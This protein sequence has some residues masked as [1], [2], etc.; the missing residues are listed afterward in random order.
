[1][2]VIVQLRYV[3]YIKTKYFQKLKIVL[4]RNTNIATNVCVKQILMYLFN[5]FPKCSN[6]KFMLGFYC[7][8]KNNFLPFNTSNYCKTENFLYDM[9]LS[10]SNKYGL[11]ISKYFLKHT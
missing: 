5:I 6:K 9:S 2:F 8:E 11:I 7:A 4:Y 10:N 3:S 1:M